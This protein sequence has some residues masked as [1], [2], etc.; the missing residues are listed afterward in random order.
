MSHE[1]LIA[2]LASEVRPVTPLR[3]PRVRA[4]RWVL[5]ALAATA[6]AVS[7]AGLR[8]NWSMAVA[9]PG[10]VVTTVLVLATGIAAS[11]VAMGL[12]VPGAIERAWVRWVPL[13]LLL[14]WGGVITLDLLTDGGPL[15]SAG[16]GISC[17]WKTWGIGVGPA[18][19][20]LL[21]ARA[22]APLDWRWTGSM[23]AL[24]ALAFGVLGTELICPA[25]G[26]AHILVWHFL[27]V[28]VTTV[29]AFV[30]AAVVV[31]LSPAVR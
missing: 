26:Q 12:A 9:D 6:V 1:L 8:S 27:P 23:A 28:L 30:S 20:L 22:A 13:G 24:A 25:T 10:Y 3:P 7:A 29:A 16:G 5:L 17:L 2:T 15:R 31:R 14:L 21:M 19:V 18:A 11:V 4:A